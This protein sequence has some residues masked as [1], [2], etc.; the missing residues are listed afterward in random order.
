MGPMIATLAR[1]LGTT[2]QNA[3]DAAKSERGYRAAVSRRS[4]MAAGAALASGSVFGFGSM[5]VP[6]GWLCAAYFEVWLG[7]SVGHSFG[8]LGAIRL[9]VYEG[10]GVHLPQPDGPRKRTYWSFSLTADRPGIVMMPN[11]DTAYVVTEFQ[12]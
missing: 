8:G 6:M 11:P 7:H 3:I 2:E 12:P 1:I 10:V 9:P 5:L 4:F